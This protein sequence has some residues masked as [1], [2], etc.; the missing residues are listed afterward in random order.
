MCVCENHYWRK[1]KQKLGNLTFPKIK[2]KD[3]NLLYIVHTYQIHIIHVVPDAGFM[4]VNNKLKLN[5]NKLKELVVEQ[6]LLTVWKKRRRK[7]ER[8]VTLTSD[9]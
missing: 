3:G 9:C 1:N 4:V 6:S 5:I 8:G 7:E 2:P